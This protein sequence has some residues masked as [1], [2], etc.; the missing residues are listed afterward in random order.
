MLSDPEK[1]AAYDATLRAAD[2]DVRSAFVSGGMS[3]RPSALNV[4]P[5]YVTHTCCGA[6]CVADALHS[7]RG[8]AAA[9]HRAAAA[10]YVGRTGGRTAYDS[11]L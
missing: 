6:C 1:R 8:P 2:T 9:L 5:R 10:L 3:R 7:R 4:S 11:P